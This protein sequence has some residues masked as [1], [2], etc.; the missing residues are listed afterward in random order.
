MACHSGATTVTAAAVIFWQDTE[1]PSPILLS[2]QSSSHTTLPFRDVDQ[3]LLWAL[4]TTST[5]KF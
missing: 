5:P 3:Q 1:D 4:S 2:T